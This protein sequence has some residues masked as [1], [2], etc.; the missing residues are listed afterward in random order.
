M[1]RS[2]VRLLVLASAGCCFAPIFTGLPGLWGGGPGLFVLVSFLIACAAVAVTALVRYSL[3][4]AEPY[5]GASAYEQTEFLSTLPPKYVDLAILGSAAASLL[6]ELAVIRWQA[7]VFEFFAFYKNFGLLSCFVGLGLGYALANRKQIPLI[8]TIPLLAWQFGFMIVLRFGLGA[9]GLQNIRALP[10]REQL[11]MGLGVSGLGE[12]IAIYFL[13]A[14]VFLITTLAFIPVGQLCGRLME[15]RTKLRAYG[16]NLLGSL[17]GVLLM[18]FAS[19]LWTPPLV[20]FALCFLLL[21]LFH[22]RKPGSLIIGITSVIACILILVWPVSPLWQR[23]YSPYQL[24][25]FGTNPDNGLMLIRAAGHYYQRIYD[26]SPSR[27][28]P[29]LEKVRQYYEFPYHAHP[30][31][32]DVAI[33]GA[34]TGNDVAAALRSGAV[35]VDAIEIDP[36]ILM[37]GKAN[38][39]EKPYSDPRVRAIVNDARSFLRTTNNAY[40]LI[41]YGLLDSHTLTSQASSVRL[42]SFVYTVQGLREARAR[43]KKDNGALSLSFSVLNVALGRKL[44]MMMQ[45][46]FD[47]RAPLCLMAGYDNSVIFMESNDKD[48]RAPAVLVEQSGFRD[49]TGD[50]AN[51]AI[52]ADPSTD[53]WPF[54]Y[55]PRRIYPISYLLMVCQ[56]L[57]LSVFVTGNFFNQ[58]PQFSHVSFFCLGVGF[59]L[60]ETKGITEMGLTFGNTWQVT[61]IVI[62]S[63]LIMAFLANCTVHWLNIR[64]PAIPYL[65]IYASLG[66]GWYIA[67]AGGLPSGAMG[68]LGTV[69]ILT[70]PVFF[71]GVI[72]STLLATR[73]EIA[74]IM[75]I[76]LL[77]AVCGGLLEYNSMYFGFKS[78]YLMALGAYILAFLFDLAAA[79]ARPQ[80][81]VIASDS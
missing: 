5:L 61:G 58:R 46:A 45:E 55:M 68:N 79:M 29:K 3:K 13:L 71:S 64:R 28:D 52:Q 67:R 54:F 80:S 48:W 10:F 8:L 49:I 47:G 75:A 69:I 32:Q 63:I 57:I 59:M 41:V 73:G 42:D 66:L 50:F 30:Q 62:A 70:C 20:W 26:F 15:G 72:F 27:T 37:A 51:P 18:F 53:D 12:A 2:F 1:I 33:V 9:W 7:T 21:L 19:V 40:D 16:L 34:G 76:N 35:H 14:V 31:L 77:G 39:P 74:G 23:L 38:H 60:V 78:L 6:L 4:R 56:V 24:L 22:S 43:L 36:A 81:V 11:N 25:E 65:L 44:Y 17:I